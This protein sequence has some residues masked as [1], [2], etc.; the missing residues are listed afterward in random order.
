M[1]KMLFAVSALALIA[2]TAS[3]DDLKKVWGGGDPAV[4]AYSGTYVPLA[5]ENL[6]NARLVGY[7][8]GGK[9]DGCVDN[10]QK[11]TDNPT[12]LAICQ[13]DM[14]ASEANKAKYKYTVLRTDLGYECLYAVTALPG[15]DNFGHIQGNAFD[16]T[17]HT[18]G[19]AS[20]SMGSWARLA[21]VYPEL[22][23]VTVVN[24]GNDK[25]AV[26]AAKADAAKG[27]AAIAFFVKRP[28]PENA[29]FEYISQNKMTFIPVVESEIEDKGYSFPDLPVENAG[30]GALVGGKVKRIT[31]ACTSI[32]LIT[33]DPA[34]LPANAP[35][36]IVSRLTNTIER[37][38]KQ[39]TAEWQPKEGWFSKMMND[40]A[41]TAPSKLAELKK[42]AKDTADSLGQKAGELIKQN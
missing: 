10:M 18:T 27:V 37:V 25:D 7:E 3:A 14:V 5:I 21:E 28:D 36:K 31:T 42:A 16:L 17:I 24:H 20:G 30:W 26:A 9:S 33:G 29:T 39:S 1:R 40:L 15:Y 23:D 34:A 41:D 12:N 32:A 2:S 8:W 11:V 22:A 35:S 13:G 4:S 38:Q 19:A 6:A